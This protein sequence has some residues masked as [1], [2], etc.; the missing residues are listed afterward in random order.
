MAGEASE[1]ALGQNVEGM[2]RG[3]TKEQRRA[4]FSL[5]GSLADEK[6]RG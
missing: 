5:L 3:K 4:V 2:W 1:R 6:K